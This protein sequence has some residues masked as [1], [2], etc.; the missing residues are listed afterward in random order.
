[1][2]DNAHKKGCGKV[3]KWMQ[4]QKKLELSKKRP[5]YEC[6]DSVEYHS[7]LLEHGED[8]LVACIGNRKTDRITQ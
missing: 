6:N 2:F 3:M 4:L 5:K 1:M 7:N 8:K